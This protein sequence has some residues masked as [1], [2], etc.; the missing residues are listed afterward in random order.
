MEKKDY[1]IHVIGAGVSG[2]IAAK[3]LEDHGYHPI[4]IEATDRAGGRVKSDIIAG[5]TLDHGFQVLLTAYPAAKK[6]LDL[7]ALE[8]QKFMP[9]A[10]IFDSGK[11]RIIGDALRDISLLIPTLFSG[12]GNFSDKLKVLKLNN[13]LKR[14]SIS[15]LF[16]EK[17]QTTLS[18]LREFGFSNQMIDQFFKPF[19]SGIFLE[20]DLNTSSRMFQFVYK[21]FG[22]GYAALPKSGIEA[23]PKQLA[24]NLK[25]TTFR[26][27]TSVSRVRN[28]EIVLENGE[29]VE[30][31][32]TIVA[33][34]ASNLI[35]NLS[36]QPLEWNSCET[37]YF[38]TKTRVVSKPF[39]GLVANNT[40]LINNLFYHTSLK[41]NGNPEHELLS[42]T[43]VKNHNL[44][45]EALIA[46]VEEE[47]K[48]HC[49]IKVHTFIKKYTIAK[50]LPKLSSLHYELSP[51]E[52]RL[53]SH[54]FLAGDIQLNG[55]LN[56]AMISGERAAL[57]LIQVISGDSY[58]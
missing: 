35:E 42:V 44:S 57:G 6:Y 11:Q 27:N 14:K 19:F 51:S 55:S 33:T 26:Y 28:K 32:Y 2:L 39:I 36:N 10:A 43:V 34:E 18:Y 9:G 30:T 3:V 37:L 8:L 16:M 45:P 46:K 29:I 22:A 40:A 17:E 7:E 54:I 15:A 56:A 23:I 12:I 5:Y 13:R 41:N 48:Q 1:K 52:T 21:M 24:Q 25:K 50:A 47:L 31:D 20:P 49:N 4:I 38:E 53:T 58:A